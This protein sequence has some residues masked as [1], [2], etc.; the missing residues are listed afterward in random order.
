[1]TFLHTDKKHYMICH[2]HTFASIKVNFHYFEKWRKMLFLTT[3][4]FSIDILHVKIRSFYGCEKMHLVAEQSEFS[5]FFTL[6]V[7]KI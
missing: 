3:Q 5:S 7:G 4:D 2:F 1:M 6:A